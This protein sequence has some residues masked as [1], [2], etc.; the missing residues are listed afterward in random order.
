V[1]FSLAFSPTQLTVKQGSCGIAQLLLMPLHGFSGTPSFTCSVSST[2]GSTTCSVVPAAVL[3]LLVPG[4]LDNQRWR[5]PSGIILLLLLACVIAMLATSRL[6]ARYGS[7][8]RGWASYVPAANLLLLCMLGLSCAGSSSIPSNNLASNSGA[9]GSNSAGS[10]QPVAPSVTVQPSSQTVTQG[11]PATFSVSASGTAPLSYQWTRNG[12]AINGATA[13][14][15]STGV[16]T[17][18]NQGD[19][20]SVIVSNSAGVATSNSATLSIDVP[21]NF[22]VQVPSTAATGAG[23]LTVTAQIGGTSHSA[24]M[25]LNVN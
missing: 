17:A 2:L 13:S 20:F 8:G 7:P 21:Y 11:Q 12:T 5:A 6:P 18:S 16:T 24:Q 25:A 4:K 19:Q 3:S 15:Y 22:V 9:N 1:D 14:S 10:N 23:T